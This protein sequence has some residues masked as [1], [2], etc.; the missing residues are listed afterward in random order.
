[1]FIID[2]KSIFNSDAISSISLEDNPA[3]TEK[4]FRLSMTNGNYFKITTSHYQQILAV[5]TT[6]CECYQLKDKQDE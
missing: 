4:C 6:T 3:E 5:L 2:E 1:M